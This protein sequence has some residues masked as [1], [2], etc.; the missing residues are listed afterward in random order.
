MAAGCP[1]PA[2]KTVTDVL[3]HSA[4]PAPGHSSPIVWGD[5]VFI[6]GGT[7]ERRE[8]FCYNA[9]SGALLWATGH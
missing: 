6:S 8:V 2:S 9:S 1:S 3:W 4:I 5:R 7:A